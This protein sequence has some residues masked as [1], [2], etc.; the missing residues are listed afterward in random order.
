MRLYGIFVTKMEFVS[1]IAPQAVFQ[2]EVSEHYY[3]GGHGLKPLL[4][5]TRHA[6]EE[7]RKRIKAFWNTKKLKCEVRRAKIVIND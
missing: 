3:L 5:N 7:E 1:L 2:D 6:A 4:F